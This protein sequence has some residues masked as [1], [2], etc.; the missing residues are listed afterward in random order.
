MTGQVQRFL[1]LVVVAALIISAPSVFGATEASSEAEV[2][3][4]TNVCLNLIETHCRGEANPDALQG[5][6]STGTLTCARPDFCFLPKYT[7]MCRAAVP[8]V[9]FNSETGTCEDFIYGGCD[10]NENNFGNRKDCEDAC[11]GIRYCEANT[12]VDC[13]SDFECIENICVP[14]KTSSRNADPNEEKKTEKDDP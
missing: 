12:G 2:D 5:C 3:A 8:R 4:R 6:V 1:F 10:A 13:P 7:G 11:V 14:G 9:Y